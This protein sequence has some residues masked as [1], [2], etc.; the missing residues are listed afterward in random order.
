MSSHVWGDEPSHLPSLCVHTSA[1]AH[2][3]RELFSVPLLWVSEPTDL[4]V[5][6]RAKKLVGGSG[7]LGS[8]DKEGK[9]GAQKGGISQSSLRK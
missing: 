7:I 3:S 8:G 1:V 9:K 2:V 6:F 4:W 5:L